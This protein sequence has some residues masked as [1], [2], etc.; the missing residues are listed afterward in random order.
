VGNG[1]YWRHWPLSSGSWRGGRGSSPARIW[2]VR[3]IQRRCTDW[4]ALLGLLRTLANEMPDWNA[5][6]C[7]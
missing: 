6:C 2:L 5:A 1:R 7:A 4:R 3:A